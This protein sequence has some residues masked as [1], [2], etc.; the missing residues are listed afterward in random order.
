[1]LRKATTRLSALESEEQLLE[2]QSRPSGGAI[3]AQDVRKG[4]ERETAL[5]REQDLW[6]SWTREVLVPTAYLGFSSLVVDLQ[7]ANLGVVLMGTLA[8][9]ASVVG[10][11]TNVKG[12]NGGPKGMKA[13]GFVRSDAVPSGEARSLMATSLRVTGLQ[14]GE[15]VDRLYD[16]DD[17]GE[18]VERKSSSA[19]HTQIGA[20]QKREHA[21]T[22]AREQGKS[23]EGRT[24]SKAKKS[25]SKSKNAIDDLFAGLT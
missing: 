5:R 9:V 2:S 19:K 23:K 24:K 11:P 10:P 17:V 8:D 14:S 3:S 1:M 22:L 21:T 18:V 4:F 15:L 13:K 25:K 6:R 20:D 12:S 7:F 16:S